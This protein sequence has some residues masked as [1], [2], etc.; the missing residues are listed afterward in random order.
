MI[1]FSTC[2][3]IQLYTST[4]AVHVQEMVQ[5]NMDRAKRICWNGIHIPDNLWSTKHCLC[6]RY[7]TKII[8]E[9]VSS[10]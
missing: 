4:Q 10:Q 1:Y 5:M 6:S 3:T 8:P 7:G 9:I 2:K